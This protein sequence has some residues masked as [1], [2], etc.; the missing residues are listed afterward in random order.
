MAGENIV[1]VIKQR[2]EQFSIE[3]VFNKG[4]KRGEAPLRNRLP[5]PLIKERGIKGEELVNNLYGGGLS[6]N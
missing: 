2:R 5:S 4:I 1:S 6:D 3:D